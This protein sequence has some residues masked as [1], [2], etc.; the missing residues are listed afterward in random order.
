MKKMMLLSFALG[1]ALLLGACKKDDPHGNATVKVTVLSKDGIPAAEETVK[2]YDEA[3]YK[4][5][6]NNN[7]TAPNASQVTNTDGVVTFT[8]AEESWFAT[9][10]TRMPMFVVQHG[11]GSNVSIWSM[12]RNIEAGGRLKLTIQLKELD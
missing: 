5:F 8:L 12:G 7:T 9:Q 3:T 4:L 11:S 10:K 6:E 2:M 1:F